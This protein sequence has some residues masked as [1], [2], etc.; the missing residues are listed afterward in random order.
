MPAGSPATP[1]P[2]VPRASS[3]V[4]RTFLSIQRVED[5]IRDALEQSLTQYLDRP[6]DDAFVDT[7]IES[8]NKFLRT[9]VGR[10]AIVDGACRFDPT[11]NPSSELAAGH[12]TFDVSY[13][14]PVPAER[15]SFEAVLDTSLLSG[16]GSPA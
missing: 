3:S 5:V 14:P 10:G 2:T 6:I 9:L 7:V 11:K 1:T 15:I 4:A 12:V 13:M 16:V 8:V